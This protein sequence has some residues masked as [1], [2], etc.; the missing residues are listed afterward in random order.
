ME[1]FGAP[2]EAEALGKLFSLDENLERALTHGFH[3]YP[4]RMHWATAA[5]LLDGLSLHG[6]RVLDPL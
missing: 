5:H 2:A 1:V 4:A 6:A 3:S